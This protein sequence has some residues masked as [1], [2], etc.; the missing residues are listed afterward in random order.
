MLHLELC[1]YILQYPGREWG[2][3]LDCT[4]A[5]ADIAVPC[6]HILEDSFFAW[7]YPLGNPY[8]NIISVQI[9]PWYNLFTFNSQYKLVDHQVV[10]SSLIH[11]SLYLNP[12]PAEP[13]YTMPSQTVLIQISWLLKKPNDLDLHCLPLSMWIYINNLDEII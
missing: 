10:W 7:C 4:N 3:W 13:R 8:W 1:L 9:P 11:I 2:L 6:L 12:C 5:Q